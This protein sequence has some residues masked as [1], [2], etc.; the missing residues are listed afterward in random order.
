[1]QP[2]GI[3]I[4]FYENPITRFK[5]KIGPVL[6]LIFAFYNVFVLIFEQTFFVINVYNNVPSIIQELN[7]FF[8]VRWFLLAAQRQLGLLLA[9]SRFFYFVVKIFVTTI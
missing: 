1:M 7:A 8:E 2:S 5:F 6:G 9:F 3:N 4:R